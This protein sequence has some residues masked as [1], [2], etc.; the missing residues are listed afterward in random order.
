MVKFW[1][2]VL[3]YNN[4]IKKQKTQTS[5]QKQDHE[6][7]REQGGVYGRIWVEKRKGVNI[8]IIL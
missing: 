1:S 6:L 4:T 8:V 3:L 2:V 7:E 5:K